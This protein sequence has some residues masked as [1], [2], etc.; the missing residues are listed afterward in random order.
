MTIRDRIHALADEAEH[1][2]LPALADT[3]RA[4]ARG[5]AVVLPSLD[6]ADLGYWRDLPD[7]RLRSDAF[8]DLCAVAA[9]VDEIARRGSDDAAVAAGQIAGVS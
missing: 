9:A 8:F 1:E 4:A 3:L 5:D 2:G 6:G 7:E